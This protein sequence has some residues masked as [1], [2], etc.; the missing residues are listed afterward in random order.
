MTPGRWPMR[1]LSRADLDRS[2]AEQGAPSEGPIRGDPLRP[3]GVNLGSLWGRAQRSTPGRSGVELNPMCR[4]EVDPSADLG[5]TGD[6]VGEARRLDAKQPRRHVRTT[7]MHPTTAAFTLYMSSIC[8][9]NTESWVGY[10]WEGT[11]IRGPSDGG[12]GKMGLR[13]E[14]ALAQTLA[15]V[16]LTELGVGRKTA[17]RAPFDV[18]E[19]SLFL[20][21]GG[22]W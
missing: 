15:G 4:S 21:R 6:A 14:G 3:L 7:E 11:L 12:V 8:R 2:G 17:P 16:G 22:G 13:F 20:L 9:L 10:V 1:C 5:A 18:A 19:T